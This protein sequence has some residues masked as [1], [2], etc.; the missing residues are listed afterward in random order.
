MKSCRT[1]PIHS[2]LAKAFFVQLTFTSPLTGNP[3]I[4]TTEIKV[5][6][7]IP[8]GA[9]PFFSAVNPA[10]LPAAAVAAAAGADLNGVASG[11]AASAPVAHALAVAGQPM[12]IPP[13]V[14]PRE[15]DESRAA[16]QV[17]SDWPAIG[18]LV[19][20]DSAS[21]LDDADAIG[22]AGSALRWEAQA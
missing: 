8:L 11:L 12:E 3:Y 14:T 18:H 5:V 19:G 13:T 20:L 2:V 16:A 17:F 6:S 21:P 4:F 9:W 22:L 10:A 7:N 1:A 15:R